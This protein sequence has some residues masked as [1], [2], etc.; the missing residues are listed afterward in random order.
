[1]P[2]ARLA[3]LK[4]RVR[5]KVKAMYKRINQK[6]FLM[7]QMN[8][9]TFIEVLIMLALVVVVFVGLIQ[10]FQLSLLQNLRASEMSNAI[11]LAQQQIDYLRTLT[12]EELAF[13]PNSQR[14]ESNDEL[15]DV[16]KDGTIDFRRLTTIET[17]ANGLGFNVR[18]LIFPAST[19]KKTRTELLANPERYRVRAD[20]YTVITR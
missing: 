15:L 19:A 17:T 16:N 1:M 6:D 20:I 11:F 7:R 2:A 18:V 13:F 3:T 12:A 5:D 10:L 8:G 9:F 14:G 4:L